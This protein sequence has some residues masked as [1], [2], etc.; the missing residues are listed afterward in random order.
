MSDIWSFD[1][2][3]EGL[4]IRCLKIHPLSDFMQKSTSAPKRRALGELDPSAENGTKRL[5]TCQGCRERQRKYHDSRRPATKQKMR[6]ENWPVCPWPQLCRRINDGYR[7]SQN[8]VL[9]LSSLESDHKTSYR[10]VVT[11]FYETC[12][13]HK[14]QSSSNKHPESSSIQSVQLTASSSTTP[15]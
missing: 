12:R 3:K 8:T 1:R 13:N 14:I 6:N 7:G 5:K 9:T 10:F 4:C 15:K 11:G 2:T